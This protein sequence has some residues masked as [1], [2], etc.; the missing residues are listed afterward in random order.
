MRGGVSLLKGRGQ[1]C[2]SFSWSYNWDK[3]EEKQCKDCGGK[4]NGKIVV[5]VGR[6]HPK[7]SRKSIPVK[8]VIIVE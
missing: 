5:I 6:E 3:R 2:S 8:F 1:G 7:E 4:G